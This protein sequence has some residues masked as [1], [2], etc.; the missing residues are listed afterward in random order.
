M[1][2]TN[3]LAWLASPGYLWVHSLLS[4]GT[5]DDYRN[6][7][8]LP[9]PWALEM[10]WVKMRNWAR[11][12]SY[13]CN[14]ALR[15]QSQGQLKAT[16]QDT[17]SKQARVNLWN[18]SVLLK[19][20]EPYVVDINHT[21]YCKPIWSLASSPKLFSD[22]LWHGIKWLPERLLTS[23]KGQSIFILIHSA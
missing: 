6:I 13:A 17:I 22:T 16:K 10:F 3:T 11:Y 21:G 8:C 14:P 23:L 7:L 18:L 19:C 5:S 4:I 1:S 20:E 12:N 15:K 2:S 9:G